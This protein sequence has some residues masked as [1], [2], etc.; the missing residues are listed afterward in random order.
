M[1]LQL[2]TD[3]ADRT[4]ACGTSYNCLK[5]RGA[6]RTSIQHTWNSTCQGGKVS[7]DL[8]CVLM[9]AG[10]QTGYI[11]LNGN[12]IY[13]LEEKFEF[14]WSKEYNSRWAQPQG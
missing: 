2:I 14:A 13:P 3:A 1:Q 6:I 7:N 10:L 5:E 4:P 9:A 11:S 8:R 12:L